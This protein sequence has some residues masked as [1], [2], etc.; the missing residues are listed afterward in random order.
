MSQHRIRVQ[1]GGPPGRQDAGHEHGRCKQRRRSAQRR[2]IDSGD[3]EHL[4]PNDEPGR[5]AHKASE[6]GTDRREVRACRRTIATTRS[7]RAPRAIRTA[8]SRTRIATL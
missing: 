4:R 1:P 7:A 6:H 8:I 5:D 2:D 3:T